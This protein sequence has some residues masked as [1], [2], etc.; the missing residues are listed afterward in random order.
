MDCYIGQIN[1]FAFGNLPK[2]WVYCNGQTLPIAQNQALYSLLGNSFGPVTNTTFTLP[3]LRSRTLVGQGVGADN[4][5][6]TLGLY[7]GAESVTLTNDTVPGHQHWVVA[8]ATAATI[9]SPANSFWA[10]PVAAVGSTTAE[11]LYGPAPTTPVP[12]NAAVVSSN[13]ESQAHDNRQP[14]L[15]LAY[16]ICIT[17]GSYPLR[18]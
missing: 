9:A 5:S 18:P 6:Y 8:D 14:N 15:A 13:G 3:D 2:G 4:N 11:Y 12:L 1:I 7:G 10:K 17:G 16:A